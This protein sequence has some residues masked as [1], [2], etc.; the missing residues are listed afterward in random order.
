MS[1]LC[2]SKTSK[3]LAAYSS[4]ESFMVH[5]SATI[6][7]HLAVESKVDH[8]FGKRCEVELIHGRGR[9]GK[10]INIIRHLLWSYEA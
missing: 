8:D 5:L 9:V 10:G 6:L 2:E 4:H 1:Q 7:Y 3:I